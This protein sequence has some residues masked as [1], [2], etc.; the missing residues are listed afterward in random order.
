MKQSF[1]DYFRAIELDGFETESFDFGN[2]GHVD[3]YAA[4]ELDPDDYTAFP[5]DIG[6]LD[7][8]VVIHHDNQGF[9]TVSAVP[10]ADIVSLRSE[11]E[12]FC[13]EMTEHD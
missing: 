12:A 5:N 13:E 11:H 1:E 9:V 8:H 7:T 4:I 10:Y 6:T 2:D 3:Y